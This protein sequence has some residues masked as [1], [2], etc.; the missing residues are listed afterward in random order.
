ML[1]FTIFLLLAGVSLAFPTSEPSDT[2]DS[3]DFPLESEDDLITDDEAVGDDGPIL[4]QYNDNIVGTDG[5]DV[6]EIEIGGATISAGDGDDT[7][8]GPE[9]LAFTDQMTVNGEGG[10]DTIDVSTI[11]NVVVFGGDGNDTISISGHNQGGAGYVM[12]ADG[13]AGDDQIFADVGG[14]TFGSASAAGSLTGG[15]G[16]DSFILHINP[17]FEYGIE[18]IDAAS[19][20]APFEHNPTEGVLELA[21]VTIEDFES[22]EDALVVDAAPDAEGYTLTNAVLDTT[23]T[24]DHYLILF[25]E[26]DDADLRTVAVHVDLN[27]ADVTED[28]ISFIGDTQPTLVVV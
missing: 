4:V 13:G 28:D 6:Y 18:G 9:E 11:A 22:G 23:T 21:C 8:F 19:I 2:N 16:A 10:D 26:P 15:D 1:P 14:I 20:S 5:D 3:E 27:G 24:D 17:F 12:Q 25:Y 7:I